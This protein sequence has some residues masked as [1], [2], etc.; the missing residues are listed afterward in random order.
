MSKQMIQMK[1]ERRN[2]DKSVSSQVVWL[3]VDPRVRMGK[4][5]TLEGET[6]WWK[7]VGVYDTKQKSEI[8][9]G[10]EVGGILATR[11]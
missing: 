1:L 2:A 5:I 10:W 9:H 8:P 4:L 3:E 7:V 6:G 11:H